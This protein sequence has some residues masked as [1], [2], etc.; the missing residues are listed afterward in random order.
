MPYFLFNIVTKRGTTMDQEGSWFPDII[1]AENEA[2]MAVRE[3]VADCIRRG[4]RVLPDA[5]VITEL[6]GEEIARVLFRDAIPRFAAN[7]GDTTFL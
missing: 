3:L 5:V 6:S 7:L 1:T 4:I 2:S